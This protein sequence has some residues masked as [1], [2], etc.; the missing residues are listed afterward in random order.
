MSEYENPNNPTIQHQDPGQQDTDQ[1]TAED[2]VMKV[3]QLQAQ[4]SSISQEK[5]KYAQEAEK[6][7]SAALGKTREKNNIH[8]QVHKKEALLRD[9]H[10]ENRYLKDELA[11]YKKGTESNPMV[12]NMKSEMEKI[13]QENAKLAAE[14]ERFSSELTV[15]DRREKI[16]KHVELLYSA[17]KD[18]FDPALEYHTKRSLAD[19]VRMT[20]EGTFYAVGIDGQ[21]LHDEFGDTSKFLS[22]FKFVEQDFLKMP[23]HLGLVKQGDTTRTNDPNK[24]NNNAYGQNPVNQ[25]QPHAPQPAQNPQQ[26]APQSGEV[27][28]DFVYHGGFSH[29][30]ALNRAAQYG[31]TSDRVVFMDT[32]AWHREEMNPKSKITPEILSNRKQL[33]LIDKPLYDQKV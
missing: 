5:D 17:Q 3:D 2:L 19:H 1:L 21:T 14:R 16:E 13:K 20:D 12:H 24:Y 15:R 33:I 6:Y 25:M 18:K 28:N 9:T 4:L 31:Y 10:E 23:Q 22:T 27:N 8:E 29:G 32:Q 7:K 11:K 30:E 26:Q